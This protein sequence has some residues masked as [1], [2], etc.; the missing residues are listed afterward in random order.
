MNVA[1][2][3]GRSLYGGEGKFVANGLKIAFEYFKEMGYPDSKL[4]IILKHIP[5]HVISEK[6]RNIIKQLEEIPDLVHWCPSR[7]AGN[8]VIKSDDDLFILEMAL[9]HQGIG[10]SN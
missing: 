10:K 4:K 8:K 5:N 1:H 2:S 6:D 3:Y 7:I 9:K